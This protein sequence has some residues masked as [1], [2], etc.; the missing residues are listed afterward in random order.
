MPQEDAGVGREYRQLDPSKFG[1]DKSEVNRQIEDLNR[2]LRQC[3]ERLDALEGRR[4][5][6]SLG[7]N[8]D[9]TG[10][11][12]TNSGDAE[13]DGD[14]VSKAYAEENYG[15]VA[16]AEA[17]SLSGPSPLNVSGLRG[18]LFQAQPAAAPQGNPDVILDTALDGTL[19]VS[20]NILYRVDASVSPAVAVPVSGIAVVTEDTLS[21]RP[22]AADTAI[23]TLFY[24]T[25]RTVAWIV[26]DS[27]GLKWKYF[28]GIQLVALASLPTPSADDGGYQAYTT[29]T[30]THYI[31]T[32]TAWTTI[33]GL[34]QIIQNAATGAV[35]DLDIRQHL[36]NAP[37]NGAAG[38]GVGR[39]DQTKNDANGIVDAVR[40]YSA[41]TIAA[42]A[43]VTSKWGVQLRSAG[44]ALANWFDVLVDGI[45]FNVGGFF[46]KLTHANTGDQVYTLPDDTGDIPY[47]V[48]G[49]D[50]VADTIVLGDGNA[51]LKPVDTGDAPMQAA[52]RTSID[53]AKIQTVGGD[54]PG[55]YTTITSI[56]VTSEGTI[57]A[58]EGT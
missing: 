26:V 30:I 37:G 45:Q 12:V 18:Q 49:V 50:F 2:I 48:T 47:G 3:Y 5:T 19:F 9:L 35:T 29:D 56:T 16:M 32:G 15:P 34:Y 28:G 51:K 4:G 10:H 7:A 17:L 40:T 14:L 57:S 53:A 54:G 24:A 1:P 43:T 44:A 27:G 21:N 22:A 31:W 25:D 55:T 36:L 33:G 46:G 38:I 58:I 13:N 11:V 20:N 23:G 6:V 39:L 52:A 42:A 8:I 41:L